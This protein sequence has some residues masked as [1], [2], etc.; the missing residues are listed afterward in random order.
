[1]P[2]Y[3]SLKIRGNSAFYKNGDCI[4]NAK[5][6]ITIGETTDSDIRM[7]RAEKNYAPE[8]YATI[9]PNDDGKSWRIIRRS[10][11]L[12]INIIGST[13]VDYVYNLQDGDIITFGNHKQTF[14]FNEHDDAEFNDD[15]TL[16]QPRN[17][18]KTVY[19][20]FA[21]IIAAV[22]IGALW[23]RMSMKKDITLSDVA[24]M[25]NSVFMIQVDS[26]VMSK[27]IDNQ[28]LIINTKR[29]DNEGKPTGT[30]FLTDDGKLLTARHC[31][32]YWLGEPLEPTTDIDSLDSDNIIKWA[33]MTETYN[34]YREEN[35][36]TVMQLVAF[37]SVYKHNEL[38]DKPLFRFSSID[39]SV[40]INY[41]HDA[42]ITLDNF[43][44][45]YSWRTITPYFNRRDMQLG[46]IMYVDVKVNGNIQLANLQEINS[47]K[48]EQ[49]LAFLGFP[50]KE[51][52]RTLIFENGYLKTDVTDTSDDNLNKT[53]E[54][55]LHTGNITHG[56]SG[57]PVFADIPG[58][59]ICAVGVVSKV[60]NRND[61]LKMSV[62][63]S[64]INIYESK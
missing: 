35:N 7:E 61:G 49:P 45:K 6:I 55:L 36:D 25:E 48:R 10:P 24:Q 53:S 59:G 29:F 23:I 63:V 16:W 22:V 46:D 52:E 40:H 18:M 31:V 32:Q 44:N 21:L 42:F 38:N 20:L 64:E 11:H 5:N 41:S 30:A 4:K 51:A 3:Y 47:M 54:L 28:L 12:D 60:D 8:Y 39:D 17:N 57:G 43:Q 37:C 62:P 50:E 26:V 9:V 56:Y 58:K 19:Y 27:S 34:M 33:A 14:L 13:S 15:K 1:M 2:K